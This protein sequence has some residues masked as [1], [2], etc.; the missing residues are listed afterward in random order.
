MMKKL[1]GL[2]TLTAL[3]GMMLVGCQSMSPSEQSIGAA[4]LGGAI[5]GGAGT[6]WAVV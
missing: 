2:C 5:G 6:M 4:A 1:L 3:S